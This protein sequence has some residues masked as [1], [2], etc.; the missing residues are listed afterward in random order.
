MDPFDPPYIGPPPNLANLPT[1]WTWQVLGGGL[2]ELI[3]HDD[4]AVE[5]HAPTIASLLFFSLILYLFI[6]FFL[7]FFFPFFFLVS[8][9][10]SLSCSYALRLL[11]LFCCL[12]LPLV[13]AST[14]EANMVGSSFLHLFLLPRCNCSYAI[15]NAM[16]KGS[17]CPCFSF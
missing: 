3:I 17:G 8:S 1:C 11:F 16:I 15:N 9:S 14:K 5:L 12:L 2:G 6:Y 10:S 7:P 13:V 4:G